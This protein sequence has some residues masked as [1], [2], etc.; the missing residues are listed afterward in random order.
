[1]FGVFDAQVRNVGLQTGH[2]FDP[3]CTGHAISGQGER[4]TVQA[5]SARHAFSSRCLH[6]SS[7][8][9][10]SNCFIGGGGGG[11]SQGGHVAPGEHAAHA[12]P[13]PTSMY[14]ASQLT[15]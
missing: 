1:L 2:P 13:L 6:G 14:S 11:Q 3:L 8:A 15:F 10:P 9:Q 5:V 12:H 7:G 4:I